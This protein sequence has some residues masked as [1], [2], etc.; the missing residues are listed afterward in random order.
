MD[1]PQ[2]QPSTSKSRVDYS[3]VADEPR[4]TRSIFANCGDN[5]PEGLFL[6]IQTPPT[7][8]WE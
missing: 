6:D 4:Y 5:L 1:E 2:P 8:D 3:W 7:E